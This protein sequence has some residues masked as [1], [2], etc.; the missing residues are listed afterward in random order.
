MPTIIAGKPIPNLLA[1]RKLHRI[2]WPHLL[3][4][5]DLPLQLTVANVSWCFLRL[6]TADSS[7]YYH[8]PHNLSRCCDRNLR[9]ATDCLWIPM[10]RT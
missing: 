4:A 2:G 8:R 9:Q 10:I 1:F 6:V 3:F 5:Q 7:R